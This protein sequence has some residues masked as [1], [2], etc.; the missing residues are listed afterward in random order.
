MNKYQLEDNID[1]YELLKKS[2]ADEQEENSRESVC[3][4]T[5]L[6]LVEPYITMKCG[7]SFNYV[8]LYKDIACVKA[9]NHMERKR[10]NANQIKC[11][12][13][14]SVENHVLPYIRQPKCGRKDMVNW[15]DISK[16]K[17][18]NFI[19]YSEGV[20]KLCEDST[21]RTV[22]SPCGK[23]HYCLEH[24]Q[25]QYPKGKAFSKKKAYNFSENIDT[26]ENVVIQTEPK[27]C[28]AILKSGTRKGQMCGAPSKSGNMCLRHAPKQ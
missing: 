4:I 1:F 22:L 9:N 28:C 2:I 27:G 15:F 24:Y 11:P 16:H 19:F 26:E 3:L 25:E 7:H 17:A 20:C 14:R 18:R 23:F 6:P 5:N 12:Y 13:C 8:P 10:L 21:K